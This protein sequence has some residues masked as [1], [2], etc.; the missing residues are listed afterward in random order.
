MAVVTTEEKKTQQ[1]AADEKKS[2]SQAM[3]LAWKNA[4]GKKQFMNRSKSR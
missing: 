2:A 1:K 4:G 3:K